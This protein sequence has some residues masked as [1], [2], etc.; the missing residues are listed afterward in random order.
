MTSGYYKDPRATAELIRDGWL[1]TGDR[2]RRD[3]SGQFHFLGRFKEI[4]KRSGENISPIE[5]EEVLKTHPAVMDAVVLG[6][7]DSLRDEKVVAFVNLRGDQ[8]VTPE[9]LKRWCLVALSAFKV[10]EEFIPCED[11]P[12]TSVGKVQRHMLRRTWIESHL[13]PHLS[14]T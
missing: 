3:G 2:A 11:F 1:H 6:V 7:P 14:N 13:A 10:P 12:R 4:I 9:E 8:P 5:V